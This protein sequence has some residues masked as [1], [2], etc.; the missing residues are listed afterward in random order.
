MNVVLNLIG[1]R[2]LT[3]CALIVFL[4][5]SLPLIVQASD[6]DHHVKHLEHI[7]TQAEAEALRPGDTIAMACGMCKNVSIYE[8][9]ENNEH[10]ELMTIGEKHTCPVCGG[11]VTVV[12]TGTGSGKNEEV[13]HV[14]SKCGDDAMF[15][16]ALKTKESGQTHR[17]GPM[18]GKMDHK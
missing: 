18:H 11:T 6:N 5:L 10:V 15:V 13:K 12:G 17:H 7:K 9:H 2:N 14:C 8:V 4:S 16:A 1:A 3:K